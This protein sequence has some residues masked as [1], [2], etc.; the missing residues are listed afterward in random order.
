MEELIDELKNRSYFKYKKMSYGCR[1]N[2]LL[3]R[4]IPVNIDGVVFCGWN[5]YVSYKVCEYIKEKIPECNVDLFL[6]GNDT[7]IKIE[8]TD[9]EENLIK[10]KI[11]TLLDEWVD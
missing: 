8:V 10:Q 1:E 11:R 4:K 3:S 6:N 5:E 9:E 7:V 2:M